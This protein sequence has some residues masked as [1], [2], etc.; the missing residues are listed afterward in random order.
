MTY[1]EKA[2]DEIA[3]FVLN[4]EAIPRM[5]RD[6]KDV[7]W[8]SKAWTEEYHKAIALDNKGKLRQ[9][10]ARRQVRLEKPEPPKRETLAQKDQRFYREAW[11]ARADK[12]GLCRCEECG[13]L[14]DYAA[15]HV[16]HNLTRQAHPALRWDH[17][18]I[19]ILCL[20]HHMQWEDS[21]KRKKMKI[22]PEKQQ[23]IKRLLE[24]EIQHK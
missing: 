22:W 15:C 19:S 11:D 4:D 21:H 2:R 3:R 7:A 8:A 1:R 23:V 17:D 9:W 12:N 20:M 10:A 18:N 13:Q 24:K 16:S 5:H 6:F 14:M